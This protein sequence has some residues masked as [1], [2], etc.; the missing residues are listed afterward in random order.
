MGSR[1][2]GTSE[3]TE[4]AG[5]L[6]GNI[7]PKVGKLVAML[8]S[9]RDGEILAT[10]AA[11]KRVLETAGLD[12]IDFGDA[13]GAGLVLH[14]IRQPSEV[15]SGEDELW[16]QQARWLLSL[17]ADLREKE[18]EFLRNIAQWIGRPSDKQLAWLERIFKEAA[19]EAG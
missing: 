7:G 2:R 5:D 12:F 16:R 6:I 10:V 18:I 8:G 13:L 4:R 9:D 15:L 17:G 14:T 19:A 11:L 3:K 1:I